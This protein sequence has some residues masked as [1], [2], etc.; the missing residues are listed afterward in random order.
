MES[1][2]LA[3]ARELALE[4]WHRLAQAEEV[5]AV[6]TTDEISAGGDLA[7]AQEELG[8]AL[9]GLGWIKPSEAPD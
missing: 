8:Y 1:Q 5:L 7:H 4:A 3:R 9:E 2:K 6:G